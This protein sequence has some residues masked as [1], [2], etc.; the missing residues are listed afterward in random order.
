MVV[1]Y[2]G[3]VEY[4]PWGFVEKNADPVDPNVTKVLSK[5][6]L[7]IIAS[8]FK[9]EKPKPNKGVQQA[10]QRGA[11]MSIGRGSMTNANKLGQQTICVKFSSQLDELVATLGE[12]NPRYVRCIKPNNNFTYDEFNSH[13]SNRQ[14]RCAGMLEAIRIRKAGYAVRIK[15]HEFVQRYKTIFGQKAKK[16]FSTDSPIKEQCLKILE[17]SIPKEEGATALWQ[18]GISKVFMKEEGQKILEVQLAKAQHDSVVYIQKCAR[19]KL[20]RMLYQRMKEAKAIMGKCFLRI[21][22][23]LRWKKL[24]NEQ[25]VRIRDARRKIKKFYRRRYVHYKILAEI[26]HRIHVKK[27][28]AEQALVEKHR[29]AAQGALKKGINELFRKKY[30]EIKKYREENRERLL[31]EERAR[32]EAERLQRIEDE[33]RAAEEREKQR[34][35]EIQEAERQARLRKEEQEREDQRRREEQE[36]E[37]RRAEQERK[38]R[39]EMAKLEMEAKRQE[40]E[41]AAA[42]AAAAAAEKEKRGVFFEAPEDADE[43]HPV[44]AFAKCMSTFQ[45]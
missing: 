7:G 21:A 39:L 20:A 8:L 41:A 42:A 30:A 27:V 3:E 14:L 23:K 16:F 24:I 18:V 25:R 11:R 9:Y 31:A 26:D 33:K 22:V 45:G 17:G 12:S 43:S 19:G 29:R 34:Q 35:F 28:R 5:S 36:R 40:R 1:H 15:M 37:D 44:M 13:D 38:D 4:D 10:P 6:T 2:A 32:K